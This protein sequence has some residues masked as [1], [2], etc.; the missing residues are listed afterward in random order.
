[1]FA[2]LQWSQERVASAGQTTI[3]DYMFGMV[4]D[5][6]D[7]NNALILLLRNIYEKVL[8]LSDMISIMQGFNIEAFATFF[9][10]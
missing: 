6:I 4:E 3:S 7:G 5:M 8:K 9:P 1:M 2:E 10:V